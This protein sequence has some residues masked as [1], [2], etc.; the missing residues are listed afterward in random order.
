MKK[1]TLIKLVKEELT[2]KSLLKEFDT[3]E[4]N[5][6]GKLRGTLAGLIHYADNK[7][8][9]PQWLLNKISEIITKALKEDSD[10]SQMNEGEEKEY[11]VEYW[12]RYGD[13]KEKDIVKVKATSEEE[14]I[15]KA[16]E[17]TKTESGVMSSSFDVVG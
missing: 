6:I 9:E 13:E 8:L 2:K 5:R 7:S 11:K 16:K 15:K 17:A 3:K 12:Y 14:A 4:I 10:F 1:S